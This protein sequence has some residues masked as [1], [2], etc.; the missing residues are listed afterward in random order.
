MLREQSEQAG[1]NVTHHSIRLEDC[2]ERRDINPLSASPDLDNHPQPASEHIVSHASINVHPGINGGINLPPNDAQQLH[3]P[4]KPGLQVVG[5][6]VQ[7]AQGKF[8]CVGIWQNFYKH[9]LAA[10]P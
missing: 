5:V 6:N 10:P 4:P 3:I 2:F 7:D 1:G 8:G 9:A